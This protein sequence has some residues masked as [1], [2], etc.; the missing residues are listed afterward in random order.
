MNKFCVRIKKSMC[1][2]RIRFHGNACV[3][4]TCLSACVFTTCLSACARVLPHSLEVYHVPQWFFFC[5]C[6]AHCYLHANMRIGTNIRY[7]DS[8]NYWPRSAR[9]IYSSARVN[10][11]GNLSTSQGMHVCPPFNRTQIPKHNCDKKNI[12]VERKK[13]HPPACVQRVAQNVAD[14]AV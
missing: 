7:W 13:K 9:V 12:Y 1:I 10:N 5:V 3:F 8:H 2:G 11:C 4:T 6:T 14:H